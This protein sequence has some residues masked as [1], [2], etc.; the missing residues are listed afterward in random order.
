MEK[1]KQDEFDAM[2]AHSIMYVCSYEILPYTSLLRIWPAFR[3]VRQAE[4]SKF[5]CAVIEFDL[6]PGYSSCSVS[7]DDANTRDAGT[8]MQ[9]T[10][11]NQM[12][13][14]RYGVALMLSRT[15]DQVASY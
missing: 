10:Y 1:V 12:S 4:R 14:A 8:P 3:A 13:R 5:F 9:K 6:I 11:R 7:R 15:K 2:L